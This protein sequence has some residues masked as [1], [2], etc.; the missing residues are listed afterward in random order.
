MALICDATIV[1]EASEKSG[2]RHQGWEAIRLGRDLYLL[3]NVA[4]D[5]NL[6]WP[7]QLLR[8][9]SSRG[10]LQFF[11]PDKI[12]I[13]DDMLTMGRTSFACAELLRAV[14]PDAKIRIF[15]MI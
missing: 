7:K 15:A 4:N 13:V 2:T 1:I 10:A 5:P 9:S 11:V 6:T 14:C 12:T 8:L 3:E